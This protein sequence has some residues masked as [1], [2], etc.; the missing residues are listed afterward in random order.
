MTRYVVGLY[1]K[2]CAEG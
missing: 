2:C 1:V